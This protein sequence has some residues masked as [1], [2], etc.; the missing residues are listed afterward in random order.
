MYFIVIILQVFCIYHAYRNN[1]DGKWYWLIIF[2]PIIGCILYLYDHFYSKENVK[3]LKETAKSAI[4]VNYEIEKLEKAVEF[5]D[6]IANKTALAYKYA[7]LGHFDKAA[8]TYKSCLSGYNKNDPYTLKQ[9][10]KCHYKIED[11]ELSI[12]YAEKLTED[13]DFAK[14]EEKLFYALSLVKIS[15]LEKAEDVFNQMDSRYSN[16]KQRMEF[17]RFLHSQGRKD[18]A[19]N[20]L[21]ELLDE[22]NKMSPEERRNKRQKKSAVSKMYNELKRA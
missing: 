12:Y 22:F 1:S 4:N 15:E 17:A 16:Y 14:S 18:E 6:S 20:K 7:E 21:D 2:L 10:V 9:L 13:K 3:N 11:Y 5:S 19:L 8:N